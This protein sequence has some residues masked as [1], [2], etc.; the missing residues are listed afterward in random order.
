[1]EIKSTA[2][3]KRLNSTLDEV[4]EK[5]EISKGD[6]EEILDDFFLTFKKFVTDET[7]PSIL[8][9]N[10]GSFRPGIGKINWNLKNA[11]YKYRRGWLDK[12]RL[13]KRIR[14]TWPIKQ[15]LIQEKLGKLTYKEWRKRYLENA[16]AKNK[17]KK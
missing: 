9:T 5:H 14:T 12:E 1:M 3:L 4:S 8:I 11:F 2:Y 16:K 17:S 13:R 15:R 10:F 6:L 7:M